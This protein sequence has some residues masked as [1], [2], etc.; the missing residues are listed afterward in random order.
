[1]EPIQAFFTA[2][3]LISVPILLFYKKH[4]V[5]FIFCLLSFYTDYFLIRIL[6]YNFWATGY[7][8]ICYMLSEKPSI[9]FSRTIFGRILWSEFF[10]MA[11]VG[12]YF[13]VLAPWYDPNS[14]GRTVTQQLPLRTVVGLIRFIETYLFFYCFYWF[15]KKKYINIDF[16]V[17]SIFT[18]VI[19][20]LVVGVI[21]STLTNGIIRKFLMPF[22][23]ALTRFTGLGGE[24]R[25][26]GQLMTM[27]IFIFMTIGINTPKLR[28]ISII[29]IVASFIGIALSFSSTAIVYSAVTILLF[30]LTGRASI[31]Y[32]LSIALIYIIGFFILINNEEFVDHQTQRIA[33]V[34]LE[35]IQTSIPDVPDFINHFEVFDKTA[36]AF[37]YLNPKYA[38]FGVGPNTI[39]I[40]SSEYMSEFEKTE[41]N[42]RIDS[43]PS[44]F[45]INIISRSGI[46]GILLHIFAYFYIQKKLKKY[47]NPVLSN[48][49]FLVFIYTVFYNNIFFYAAVGIIMGIYFSEK[50]QKQAQHSTQI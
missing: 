17:K 31:K 45:I 14:D 41:Y 18:I 48:Y 8:C 2:F 38:I 22:H 1:M 23:Y 4:K 32:L 34:A 20:S 36:A 50:N 10:I 16:L 35:D 29:G 27:S 33:Q 40:P 43:V 28:N 44:N 9:L 42:G 6:A 47:S 24:P 46:I 3:I 15:F 21:D 30:F 5:L 37:L 26:I 11:L 12:A 49:F 25:G 7:I 19:V 39:N 13:V